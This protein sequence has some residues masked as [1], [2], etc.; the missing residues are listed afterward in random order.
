MG[1]TKGETPFNGTYIER[2]LVLSLAHVTSQTFKTLTNDSDG[3]LP[4]PLVWAYGAMVNV[5]D[6][7]ELARYPDLAACAAFAH[8]HDCYWIRFDC[9]AQ[10]IDALPV[11]LEGASHG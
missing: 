5:S 8:Q 2:V 9:D 3:M 1:T 4:T 6:C 10:P 7:I 11:Y